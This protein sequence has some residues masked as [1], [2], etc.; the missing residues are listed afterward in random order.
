MTDDAMQRVAEEYRRLTPASRRHW[1]QSTEFITAGWPSVPG[2][3]S[4]SPRPTPPG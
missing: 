3:T 2:T 1:E 4:T